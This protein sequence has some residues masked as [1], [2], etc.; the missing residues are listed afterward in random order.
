MTLR[1]AGVTDSLSRIREFVLSFA[2][3]QGFSDDKLGEIE[4]AVDEAATN[5]IRHS[6]AED[7]E[8]PDNNR[9]LEIEVKGI[10]KGLEVAVSDFGKAFNPVGVPLPDL[11]KHA[12]SLK[13]H[14][15]G[16]FSMKV[17]MDEMTHEFVP[18]IGN[19][20]IMRKFL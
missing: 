16:I 14:G 12:T 10:E 11:E 13:T 9:V 3:E 4:M 8:I 7:P 15:L 17:F 6:Y 18:G 19:K 1:I 5:V 2:K 20:I